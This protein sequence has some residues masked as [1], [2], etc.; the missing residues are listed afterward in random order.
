[1]SYKMKRGKVVPSEFYEKFQFD[2]VKALILIPAEFEGETKNYLFDTGAQL[3]GIQRTELR[4][5]RVDVRGATNRVVENGTET[6]KSFKIKGVDFKKTFATNGDFQGLKEQ[7]PN[8]GGVLGRPIIDR[9]NWLIDYPNQTVAISNR[10]L[11]DET[12][13][14]IPLDPNESAPYTMVEINGKE[15][16]AILDLGSISVF[17]V[18]EDTDLAKEL[19][20][21]YEFVDTPRERYTV[22]GLQSIIEKQ[23]TIPSLKMGDRTFSDI[24]VRINKSSHIR[25]GM[26]FFR[27]HQVYIDN[28]N[29]KYRMK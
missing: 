7:V 11:S 18:P 16:K 20:S 6:L 19:L 9:A 26:A 14:D 5:R 22:G 10:D 8:F 4:G 17:N 3:T 1:M 25:I 12:F 21:K 28:S 15:Y 13:M 29:G 23:G 24:H 27:N 2:T